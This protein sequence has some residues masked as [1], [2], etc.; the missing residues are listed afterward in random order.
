[1]NPEIKEQVRQLEEKSA[2]VVDWIET[3][4]RIHALHGKLATLEERGLLVKIY[5]R[6][7]DV[8]EHADVVQDQKLFRQARQSDYNLLLISESRVGATVD[9]GKLL[10]VTRREIAAGHIDEEHALHKLAL[11]QPPTL[12]RQ[13]VWQVWKSRFFRLWRR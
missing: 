6:L 3:R 10:A 9:S 11:A 13:S 8:V 4:D 1:M 12:H 5:V 2:T 7:M